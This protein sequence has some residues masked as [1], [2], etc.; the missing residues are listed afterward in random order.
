M[1]EARSSDVD[2]ARLEQMQE[3]AH[4]LKA[5]GSTLTIRADANLRAET[6]II[7]VD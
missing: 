1:C 4:M 5:D 6:V 3:M 2:S 7:G